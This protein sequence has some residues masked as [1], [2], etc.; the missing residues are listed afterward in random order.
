MDDTT[1]DGTP[2]IAPGRQTSPFCPP[3][4]TSRH[5]TEHEVAFI[6]TPGGHAVSVAVAQPA[7]AADPVVVALVSTPRELLSSVSLSH[8][9][10]RGLA[11]VLATVQPTPPAGPVLLPHGGGSEEMAESPVVV[12][13]FAEALSAAADVIELLT[14]GKR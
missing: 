13:A 9:Q 11:Q 6:D 5:D 12:A 3:W 2:R 7:D 8:E 1:A 10:A 4:C 14:M